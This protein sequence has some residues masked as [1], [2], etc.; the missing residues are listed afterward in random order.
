[1]IPLEPS[2][3]TLE[4]ISAHIQTLTALPYSIG[5]LSQKEGALLKKLNLAVPNNWKVIT[6]STQTYTIA[7]NIITIAIVIFPAW[8]SEKKDALYKEILYS[9]KKIAS[10]ASIVIAFSD[11]GYTKEKEFLDS[12]ETDINLLIGAGTGPDI[13]ERQIKK[14]LW[15]RGINKGKAVLTTL[16]PN[17]ENLLDAQS[18]Y[19][20]LKEQTE[21]KSIKKIIEPLMNSH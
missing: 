1:M 20:L 21:D 5:V 10:K 3:Y 13:I 12:T 16:Y 9:S 14:T 18:N 11:W 2:D 7:N 15:K 19:I 8:N 17:I 4:K 6:N